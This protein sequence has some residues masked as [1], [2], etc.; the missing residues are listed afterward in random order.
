MSKNEIK[1]ALSDLMGSQPQ[2][3]KKFEKFDK[4][5]KKTTAVAFRLLKSEKD[6][7]R[8]YFNEREGISLSAGIKK[9]LYEYLNKQNN[10]QPMLF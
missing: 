5:P 2:K 8:K 1:S 3:T 7:I 9:A 4:L 10:E 6:R